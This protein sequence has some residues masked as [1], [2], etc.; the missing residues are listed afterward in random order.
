MLGYSFIDDLFKSVLAKSNAIQG[1]FIIA[2]KYGHELNS[3]FLGQVLDEVKSLFSEKKYPLSMLMPPVY[4]IEREGYDNGWKMFFFRQ[5]FLNTTYYNSSNQVSDPNQYT[6]TSQHTVV[7][8]WDDMARA[9]ENFVRVL[10]Y[11]EKKHLLHRDSFRFNKDSK[12]VI[13]PVSNIGVD[14]A[15]GVRIDFQ[16]SLYLGCEIEDYQ[17]SDLDSIYINIDAHPEHN[18]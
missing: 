11:V 5:F 17:V 15:S 2:P 7:H 10:N 6:R 4:I 9:A 1:R 14:R 12:P 13:T 16:A 3:D 18:L 8:D